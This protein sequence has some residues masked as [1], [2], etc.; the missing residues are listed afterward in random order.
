MA[1]GIRATVEF[2]APSACSVVDRTDGD[3][4]TVE[5]AS[6]AVTP[7]DGSP[8]VTDFSVAGELREAADLSPVF[9]GGPSNWYRLVHD[10]GATCPCEC[11]GGLGVPV[12]R[13][14]AEEGRLTLV[15]YAVDYDELKAVVA[16]LQD[17]FSGVDIKRFVR[18]PSGDAPQDSVFVDRNRLTDRQLE[19]LR[20]ALDMGYFERPRRANASEVA[21]ALDINPSTFSEHLAAAQRKLLGDVLERSP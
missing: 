11:L 18:S 14:V 20:T 5:G 17:R 9:S 4:T 12:T 3:G 6:T 21:D 7:A 16:E 1:D 8:A 19:V 2:T 10:D 15:F 13:Y